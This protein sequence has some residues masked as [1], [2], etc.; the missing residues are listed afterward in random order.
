[1]EVSKEFMGQ[2]ITIDGP[3]AS[4]K[5]SVSRELAKRLGWSWVST[6]AFYRGLAYVAQQMKT[7]LNNEDA[8]ASL[9]T[10][11][12]LWRVEMRDDQTLVIMGERDVTPEIFREDVGSIASQISHFPKVRESLLSAQRLC[13]DTTQGLVAE[14]RDCGTVVFPAAD[15]KVY[16]TATQENRAVRRAKEQGLSAEKTVEDQRIRDQQDSS[17][18]VAPL[19]VPKEALV[20]DST[21]LDLDQV[22]NEI[23]RFVRR[24]I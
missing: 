3:S 21:D 15:A 23:E 8:L 18:K 16:L 1:M 14:G 20:L 13:R 10:D 2:V 6:G 5:T 22:V 19:Q 9:A 17:R 7:D 11:Q 12:N 24:L 4:G